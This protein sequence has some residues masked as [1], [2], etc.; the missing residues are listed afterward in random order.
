MT[1]GLRIVRDDRLGPDA[2]RLIEGSQAEMNSLY[3]PDVCFAFSPGELRSSGTRFLVGWVDAFAVACG[4]IAPLEGY[5]ELKRIYVEP[6]H[7]GNGHADAIVAA[8]EAE[9]CAMRLPL[10]RL[11]TGHDSPAAIGLYRRLGYTIRGPFGAYEENG[12]SVF[13]E[14]LL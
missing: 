10:V 14:K 8:L 4:G 9:A 13:L 7:R 11:E 3:P 5:S 1:S 6:A 2:L 12:S